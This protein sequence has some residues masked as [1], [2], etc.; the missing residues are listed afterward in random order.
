MAK[1]Q[2]RK[3]TEAGWRGWA[4]VPEDYEPPNIF[5]MEE[6]VGKR[7]KRVAG[8]E[9]PKKTKI[10]KEDKP[11]PVKKVI[12]TEK[13]ITNGYQHKTI[14]LHPDEIDSV[15]DPDP[16][17]ALDPNRLRNDLQGA[18]PHKIQ[19]FLFSEIKRYNEKLASEMDKNLTLSHKNMTLKEQN[20]QQAAKIVTLKQDNLEL[21]KL[22]AEKGKD[23]QTLDDKIVALE[24]R[25]MELEC[26]LETTRSRYTADLIKA[27]NDKKEKPRRECTLV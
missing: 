12:L 27:L 25:N 6:P 11:I 21:S 7:S 16:S 26:E 23:Y 19:A 14:H 20:H 10:V 15:F 5:A 9:S 2:K 1:D 13:I 24:K 18:P 17:C 3:S 4:L 8:F 22:V